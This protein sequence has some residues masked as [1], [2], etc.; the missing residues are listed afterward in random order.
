MDAKDPRIG[1]TAGGTL[2]AG[3][4]F[5]VFRQNNTAL[6]GLICIIC[7]IIVAGILYSLGEFLL[8]GANAVTFENLN[9]LYNRLED[10]NIVHGNYPPQQDM[11]SLLKTL[12]LNKSD[13]REVLFF[14]ISSAEYHAPSLNQEDP[15]KKLDDP[16]LSLR[17]KSHVFGKDE[18]LCLKRDGGIYYRDYNPGAKP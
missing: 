7:I 17:V 1:S 18:R 5:S 2:G 11:K 12:G 6:I 10:Y 3:H 4:V 13:F 8:Y 14:D 16:V 9:L 15:L